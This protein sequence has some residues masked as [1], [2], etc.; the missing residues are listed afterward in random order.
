MFPRSNEAFILLWMD[1]NHP[2]E[3][4]RPLHLAVEDD[5]SS[6]AAAA[7]A[8]AQAKFCF[9][10]RARGQDANFWAR[11][12]STGVDHCLRIS[13]ANAPSPS[14]ESFELAFWS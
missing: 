3:C 4:S 5:D 2:G 8:A 11:S 10:L 12:T 9:P 14:A 6:A 1:D 13:S 7:A